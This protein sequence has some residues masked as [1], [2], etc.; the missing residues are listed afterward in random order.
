M[1]VRTEKTKIDTKGFASCVC[2][3]LIVFHKLACILYF[4]LLASAGV[5]LTEERKLQ[6]GYFYI[7]SQYGSIVDGFNATCNPNWTS[8]ERIVYDRIKYQ[9]VGEFW[10]KLNILVLS[11]VSVM[12]YSLFLVP[13][14]TASYVKII[15]RRSNRYRW[16][17]SA[18]TSTQLLL[19]ILR[20]SGEINLFSLMSH[21]SCNVV[22]VYFYYLGES[23]RCMPCLIATDN[24]LKEQQERMIQEKQQ[25]QQSGSFSKNH[26]RP[27]SSSSAV[28][29]AIAISNTNT[30]TKR[31]GDMVSNSALVGLHAPNNNNLGQSLIMT[32]EFGDPEPSCLSCLEINPLDE[33]TIKKNCEHCT[34]YS[35][36]DMRFRYMRWGFFIGIIPWI[37]VIFLL[38]K[39]GS[40]VPIAMNVA[41]V[42]GCMYMFTMTWLSYV[43]IGASE[44]LMGQSYTRTE[45]NY[46]F[47]SVLYTLV[48]SNL[49]LFAA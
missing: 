49:F 12:Y 20:V 34:I 19:G 35:I 42:F 2:K 33:E 44:A 7:D 41:C 17:L 16:T 38:V 25:Q 24:Q 23:Y 18:F 13:A 30:T 9:P 27:S 26:S 5:K 3:D 32:Q 31:S 45:S 28:S 36:R 15:H 1:M 14:M 6:I 11:I 37:Y 43:E 4:I 48:I 40:S 22:M 47:F 39:N 46:S 21:A 8:S 29:P 10:V